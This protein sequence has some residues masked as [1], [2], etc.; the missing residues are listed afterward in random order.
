MG[1]GK[2]IP[3]LYPLSSVALRLGVSKERIRQ[4]VRAGYVRHIR[5]AGGR[6]LVTEQELRRLERRGWPGR[7]S[8]SGPAA[9]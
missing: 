8:P 4:L 6:V 9:D 3:K 5:D 2:G 7:R 1:M